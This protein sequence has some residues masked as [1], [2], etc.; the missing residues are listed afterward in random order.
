MQTSRRVDLIAIGLMALPVVAGLVLW[1]E[2]PARLAIHWSG[3]TPDTYVSKPVGLLGIF[4]FG[5]ATVLFVRYAPASMTNT[6]GGKDVSVLFLG[7]V[8][9]WV[10]TT[11]LVWNLGHRFDVGLSV[12]P[13]LLL[14]GL[15]VVYSLLRNR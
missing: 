4:A 9:A 14:A 15:L 13:I 2:L 1:P 11:I 10:Q 12:V 8:F 6:P 3:G 5:V 7:V